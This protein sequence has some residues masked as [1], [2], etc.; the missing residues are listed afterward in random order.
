MVAKF[1]RRFG[2]IMPYAEFFRKVLYKLAG[3]HGFTT[4]RGI[5]LEVFKKIVSENMRQVVCEI[6]I[7]TL[8]LWGDQDGF[9]PVENA[10]FLKENIQGSSFKLFKDEGHKLPYNRPRE[11]AGEIE[12][13]YR[14][15]V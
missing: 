9:T 10:H 7:P 8:I 2:K 15:L 5:M 12:K 6:R 3:T 14:L 4:T 11:V 13:W 1:G